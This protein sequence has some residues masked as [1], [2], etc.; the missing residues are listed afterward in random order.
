MPKTLALFAYLIAVGQPDGSDHIYAILAETMDDAIKA[1]SVH[2]SGR[3]APRYAGALGARS[4]EL[5][6]LKNGEVRL[7]GT[8]PARDRPYLSK[9]AWISR[10]DLQS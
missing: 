9:D 8:S 6:D 3:G 5:M 1:A 4:V 7:I 10:P 2:R